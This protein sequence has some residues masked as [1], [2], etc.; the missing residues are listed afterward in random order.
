ME[1]KKE[2]ALKNAE[3]LYNK[4]LKSIT[5][6]IEI[7]ADGVSAKSSSLGALADALRFVEY[8]KASGVKFNKVESKNGQYQWV[9]TV[10]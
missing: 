10:D 4:R 9:N 2:Q 5:F 6:Q 1:S 3:A 7:S 8:L